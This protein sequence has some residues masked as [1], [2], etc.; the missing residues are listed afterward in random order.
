MLKD[1]KVIFS[2]LDQTISAEEFFKIRSLK[3]SFTFISLITFFMIIV[4]PILAFVIKN[5]VGAVATALGTVINFFCLFLVV[6]RKPKAGCALIIF[7]FQ[8]LILYVFYNSLVVSPNKELAAPTMITLMAFSIVVFV[9]SG[10][11]VNK[12]Y[13]LIFGIVYCVCVMILVKVSNVEAL[14]SRI[15]L[16]AT[17]Y[18]VLSALIYYITDIQDKI[19]S[20]A[21]LESKNSRDALGEV[22]SIINKISNFKDELDKSQV[23]VSDELNKIDQIFTANSMS[24]NRIFDIY[25]N[26]D[27]GLNKT[28]DNLKSFISSIK[29]IISLITE[30][31]G[32]IDSHSTS[33]ESLYQTIGVITTNIKD[34]D[35]I[36]SNLSKMAEEGK[37]ILS[38]STNSIKS[39]EEYQ[40]K[41]GDIVLIISNVASQT[42]LLAM[43]ASIEAAHAGEKGRGFSVVA[44]EI[45]KLA[46]SSGRSAKE[47]GELINEMSGKITESSD[48]TKNVEKILFDITEYVSLS[49]KSISNISFSMDEFLNKVR[50]LLEEIRELVLI[51]ESINKSAADGNNLSEQFVLIF[52]QFQKHFSD[53]NSTV[54][55]MKEQ[56][57]KSEEIMNNITI[58]KE[59]NSV[60]NDNINNI[61]DSIK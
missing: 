36:N 11:L 52:N 17:T 49:Y 43:N 40:K 57:D 30:Q 32:I 16:F 58:I 23:S 1:L 50:L 48:L 28:K 54:M 46:E 5:Q 27:D 9:P 41:M 6:K 21:M 56:R 3:I 20:K 59:E 61:L 33:Q 45:K 42:N 24:I 31:K 47:I 10:I 8:I 53:F 38:H 44:K 2:K 4:I 15:P 26:L 37:I 19:L 22:K 25:G 39:V 35:K 13:S 14:V 34:T 7:I 18:I 51:T 55:N 29:N 12:F 60:I